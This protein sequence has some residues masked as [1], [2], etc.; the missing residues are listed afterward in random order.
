[1]KITMFSQLSCEKIMNLQMCM[2]HNLNFSRLSFR[3]YGQ[4]SH[5]NVI[6]ME[7]VEVY[8]REEG[9]GFFLSPSDV[10]I[11]NPKANPQPKVDFICTN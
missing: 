3:S 2:T 4:N 8:Y 6:S 9:G 10:N 11:M 1:M 7:R 5:F